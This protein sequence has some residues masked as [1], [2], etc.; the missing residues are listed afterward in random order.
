MVKI[1]TTKQLNLYVRL[2][3]KGYSPTISDTLMKKPSIAKK[4]LAM[5]VRKK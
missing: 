2:R 5:K 3:K 1:P 4:V